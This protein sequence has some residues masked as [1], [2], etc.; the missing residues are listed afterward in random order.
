MRTSTSGRSL[1]V[2][3]RRAPG[4]RRC[5]I[6]KDGQDFIVKIDYQSGKHEEFRSPVFENVTTE[7]VKAMVDEVDR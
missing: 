3:A 4:T 2:R 7:M 5:G 1:L 6:F